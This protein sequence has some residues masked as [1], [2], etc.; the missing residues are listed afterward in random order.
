MTSAPVSL[1]GAARDRGL[2]QAAA[3]SADD[4]ARVRRAVEERVAAGRDLLQREDHRTLMAG[5]VDAADVHA[6]A[7]RAEVRGLA[8]GFGLAEDDLLAFLHMPVLLDTAKARADASVEDG[9]STWAA[10]DGSGR[11]WVGKNRDYG[12]DH[13][14]LQRLFR[15]DGPDLPAGP[16]LCL[17]SLGAPGAFSSGIN[18]RGLALVD[19]QVPT[20]DHGPGLC[21]YFLMS[22]ILGRCAT[23]AE[24]LALIDATPH[25]GGGCLTLADASGAMAAVEL[26]HAA[27][28]VETAR[29]G[30]LARTNHH[31]SDALSG[32]LIERPGEP[33]GRSTRERL[34]TI[35][36]AFATGVPKDVPAFAH[37]LMASHDDDAPADGQGLCRHGQDGDSRTI[38]TVLFEPSARRLYVSMGPPCSTPW[39]RHAV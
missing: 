39:N 20:A 19:S 1:C 6:P 36:A 4:I 23:V 37:A 30:W 28:R 11:P 15:H 2:A 7:S 16:M 9:C 3:A 25:A 21:R 10:V 34:E 14:A 29:Q 17:G 26:G 22:E 5:C 38:S 33:M 8:E 18:A 27:V 24:A 32:R 31:L 35:R 12:G 13:A